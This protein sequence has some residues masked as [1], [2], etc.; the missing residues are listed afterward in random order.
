MA[1][2]DITK[3]ERVWPG[4]YNKDGTN[5]EVSRGS[6][7]FQVIETIPGVYTAEASEAEMTAPSSP[8]FPLFGGGAG[9]N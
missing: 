7:S 2:I 8:L 3:T 6:L 1:K 9:R 5:K 4:K